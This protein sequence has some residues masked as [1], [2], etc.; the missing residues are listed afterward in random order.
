MSEDTNQR[1][2]TWPD[3]PKHLFYLAV[4]VVVARARGVRRLSGDAAAARPLNE[5]NANGAA[6]HDSVRRIGG[7]V[8]ARRKAEAPDAASITTVKEYK[9]KPVRA[10]ARGEGHRRLQ[11]AAEQHRPVRSERLGRLGADHLCQQ[12]LQGGQGLEDA[13]RQGVQGRARADRQPGRDAR[14]LRRGRCP[15]R[16]GDARHGAAVP[17]WLRRSQGK[18]K[19]SRIMPRIYQQVDWSNGG[20]G[21]VVRENDQDRRRPARQEARRWPRIRR[22][23]TSRSTCWSPAA[24]SRRKWRWTSPTTPSRPPPPSTRERASPAASPGRRT[25]TTWPRS[26]ATACS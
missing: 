17:R 1:K 15:H 2:Q 12:R 5:P 21:I 14:R 11:A 20:D 13:R 6:N 3:N 23:T 18:P 16:L 19:D 8:A 22:R 26:R 9:F 10:A 25:S 4:F 24:C 7:R